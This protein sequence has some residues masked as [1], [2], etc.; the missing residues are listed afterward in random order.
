MKIIRDS[1]FKQLEHFIDEAQYWDLDNSL[2]LTAG[3]SPETKVSEHESW[4]DPFIGMR[5]KVWLNPQWT[6]LGWG[7]VSVA[8]DSDSAFDL[9]A[10]V[11]YEYSDAVS[12]TAGYR[13][14]EVDYDHGDFLY[15]VEISGPI[16]G[17]TFRF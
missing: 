4:Q 13:H 17:G 15:D 6:L 16:I 10:A 11:G 8:G 9:F 3:L 5:S 2:K 1:H 7:I 14:I 12:F